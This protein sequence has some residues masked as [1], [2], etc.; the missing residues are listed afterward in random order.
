MF[1]EGIFKPK[2][3]RFCTSVAPLCRA[4]PRSARIKWDAD[5]GR[6]RWKNQGVINAGRAAVRGVPRE[7]FRGN[8]VCFSFGLK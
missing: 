6:I 7:G 4:T 3:L 2:S 1:F 5:K 8:A